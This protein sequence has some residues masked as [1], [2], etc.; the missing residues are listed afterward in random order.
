MT[1]IIDVWTLP[2]GMVRIPGLLWPHFGMGN[3]SDAQKP[4]FWQYLLQ[5]SNGNLSTSC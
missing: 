3:K 4:G 5:H 1:P 2:A